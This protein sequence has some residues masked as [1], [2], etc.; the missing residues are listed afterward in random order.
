MAARV[1][2]DRD[3][4]QL[5]VLLNDYV[6]K[7]NSI[8]ANG[9]LRAVHLLNRRGAW[10]HDSLQ[11][12]LN[13]DSTG[14]RIQ[15]PSLRAALWDT[16]RSLPGAWPDGLIDLAQTAIRSGHR[17]EM[18]STTWAAAIAFG[19]EHP[20]PESIFQA[21][22]ERATE[23]ADDRYVWTAVGAACRD[24]GL[25]FAL[26]WGVRCEERIA[27]IQLCKDTDWETWS[28]SLRMAADPSLEKWQLTR[29]QWW[30]K[31]QKHMAAPASGNEADRRIRDEPYSRYMLAMAQGILESQDRNWLLQKPEFWKWL[32]NECG[33]E[34]RTLA[35]REACTTML[36]MAPESSTESQE[37]LQTI[38]KQVDAPKL[39]SD[40][41]LTMAAFRAWAKRSD[42]KFSQW[43]IDHYRQ[44]GPELRQ[45][46]WNAM[47]SSPGRV[48]QIVQAIDEERLPA[49]IFDAAQMQ[50]L[51]GAAPAEVQSIIDR[52]LDA[53]VDRDRQKVIDRYASTLSDSHDRARGKEIFGKYC[54]P[55]HRVDGVGES[56]GP[57]ISDTRTQSAMQ[58]LVAILDPHRAVDPRYVQTV[59]RL[60][61][62]TV[63]DG[64]VVE[65]STQHVVLRNQQAKGMLITKD[66]IDAILATGKSLM[67]EGL[68]AQIDEGSMNDLIGY[69]KN[70]RYTSDILPKTAR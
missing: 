29:D 67:P 6:A 36:A 63:H 33:R 23:L 24:R 26:A 18:L 21:C 12:I 55:C 46:M 53:R 61:D 28:R 59:V 1:L 34:D 47:R 3:D 49:S 42:P 52:I 27:A 2:D 35:V 7:R 44:T 56:I 54:A 45:A 13:P 5:I 4:P 51:K 40:K 14:R 25:D 15:D 19:K 16:A 22:V 70:W 60:E 41:R 17:E 37:V 64:L 31:V 38:L 32:A 9:L 65:E 10:A 62:G 39:D 66:S 43:V 50:A 20:L 57:E 48:A 30:D 58:L 11:V 68:E 8:H 69:L